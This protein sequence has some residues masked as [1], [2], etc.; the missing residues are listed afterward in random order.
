MESGCLN[1]SQFIFKVLKRE[2]ERE[3]I[4]MGVVAELME[5]FTEVLARVLHHLVQEGR[6]PR[7]IHLLILSAHPMA[8][9][10]SPA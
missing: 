5:E 2:R 1:L 8:S 7:Q 6:L 4:L 10:S 3:M 9:S